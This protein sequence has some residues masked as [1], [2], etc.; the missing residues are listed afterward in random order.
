M[1]KD[2]IEHDGIVTSH[3]KDT[4]TVSITSVSACAGCHAKGMC[5]MAEQKDKIINISG[6]YDVNEGDKVVVVMQK[7][8][9]LP[10][11]LLGYVIPLGLVIIT[12]IVSLTLSLSEKLSGL[13]SLFILIPYYIL[14][15]FFKT[16]I[17][18]KFTFTLKL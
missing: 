6:Q 18:R 2:Y 11:V 3:G 17:D 12:L 4:V 13:L 15:R 9:G 7:K 10:A 1:N 16:G 5:T 8:L 14:L